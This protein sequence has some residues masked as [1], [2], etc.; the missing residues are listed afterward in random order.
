MNLTLAATAALTPDKAA[1]IDAATG[2]I[3]TFA[4]LETSSRRVA[5]L[6]CSLGLRTGDHIAIIM[7]NTP[8]YLEIAWAAQRSGLPCI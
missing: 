7:D 2:A 5:A 8:R 4:E 3:T 6:L 1:T